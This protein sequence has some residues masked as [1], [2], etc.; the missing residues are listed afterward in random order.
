MREIEECLE[1]L[2]SLGY[3]VSR[4]D[5]KITISAKDSEWTIWQDGTTSHQYLHSDGQL[6]ENCAS[7]W[8]FNT[9]LRGL[10]FAVA[11]ETGD[12]S[13]AEAL[14]MSWDTCWEAGD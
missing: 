7:P 5:E 14:G 12:F 11:E 9:Q 3:A 2:R 4:D 13:L 6:H 10:A 8:K 1:R